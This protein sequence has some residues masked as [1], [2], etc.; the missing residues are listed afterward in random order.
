MSYKI[1]KFD[2]NLADFENDINLRMDCYKAKRKELVGENGDLV[3]FANGHK[4]FGIHRTSCGWVY[5]E[6]AP[7]AE[8]MYFMGDFNNWVIL[9]IGT[10]IKIQ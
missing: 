3:S 8:K 4:Y 5:R 9:T 2:P 10:Y 6:W 1:I 7:A